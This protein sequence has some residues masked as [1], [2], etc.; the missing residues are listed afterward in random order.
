ME[1]GED[2]SQA[3]EGRLERRGAHARGEQN[4]ERSEGVETKLECR[5]AGRSEFCEQGAAVG[6]IR[7]EID[8]T[9]REEGR[10]CL[11]YGLLRNVE[12]AGEIGGAHT[13]PVVEEGH[14]THHG[15]AGEGRTGT[16]GV[17]ACLGELV[18]AAGASQQHVAEVFR[19]R[20][21]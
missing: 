8:E 3:P 7:V 2:L 4:V 9:G 13:G 17:D 21:S 14:E 18:E 5:H 1:Q 12:A 16:A 11:V 15:G 10:E 6:G 19:L 20:P